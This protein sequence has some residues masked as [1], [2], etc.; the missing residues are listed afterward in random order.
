MGPRAQ[1]PMVERAKRL[2][3][4]EEHQ[5]IGVCG[6]ACHE[7][8]SESITSLLGSLVCILVSW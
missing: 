2:W 1:S 3:G 8:I 4:R 5:G 7:A 6:L